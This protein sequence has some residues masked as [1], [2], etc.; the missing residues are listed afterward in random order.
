MI[1]FYLLQAGGFRVSL[2]GIR[3]AAMA[4]TSAHTR[5]ASVVF[6]NPAGMS[7]ISSKLSITGGMFAVITKAEF[8]SVNSLYKAKTD[9]PVSPP[10]NFAAAYKA[11]DNLS[12]GLSVS[13]PYGSSVDWG[14]D[15]MGKNLITKIK[16]EAFFIQPTVAYKITDWFSIGGGYIFATASANLEKAISNINGSMKLKA[17]GAP[18]Y[19]YNLGMYFRP[20]KELD[21]GISY[22]SEV[23]IKA[24]K[25]NVYLHIPSSLIGTDKFATT[26]DRFDTNIPLA[27]EL[28]LGLTYKISKCWSISSDWNFSG[29]HEYKDLTFKFYQNKIGNDPHNPTISSSSRKFKNSSAYR[30]GTE[31]SPS[32]K[33]A[34]RLGYYY[35]ESPVK[36]EYW[37]PE[38]PSTDNQAITGGL[39]YKLTDNL[40]I[41][42]SGIYFVGESRNI[43]NEN[44]GF[45][46]QVKSS[47]YMVGLGLSWNAF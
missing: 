44:A 17:G 39:G 36:D 6:F 34:F 45:Y 32:D 25:G 11:T 40:Y 9:N 1:T 35:D 3:Q 18:G 19:G 37:N 10:F 28:T 4:H 33:L 8:Q 13:T 29:W 38:T 41:D 20:T 47:S 22:R 5:D 16:L 2:Q 27:S 31:Y 46:G 7:F 12:V 42:L 23:K 14:K 43:D 26:T 15:W 21:V 24:R 30:I